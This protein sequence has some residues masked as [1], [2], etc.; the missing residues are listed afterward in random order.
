[1]GFWD[2]E[3]AN[4]EKPKTQEKRSHRRT[5]AIRT[6]SDKTY[7]RRG[8]SEARILEAMNLER[9]AMGDR[10]HFISAGD[11]DSL[12]FL[13]VV[14]NQVKHVRHLIVST[15]VLASED[16]IQLQNWIE[17]GTIEKLDI[18]VGEIFPNQYKVEWQMLKDMFSETD[19]G[20]L[21]YFRNHSKVMACD[22]GDF[23]AVIE[24]SAN[25]NTNP[26]TENTAITADKSLFEFYRQYFDGINS[27]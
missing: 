6:V 5:T 9:I 22:C 1:M 4:Q 25:I 7:Y 11:A 3:P 13:M 19:C 20:R 14:I 8:F 16:I 23:Y 12:S 15:W 17:D 24:S 2:E 26:R 21:C 10:W 18:Y 27:F